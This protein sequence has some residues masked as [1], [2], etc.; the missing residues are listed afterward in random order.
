MLMDKITP[1]RR[2]WNMSRIRSEDTAPERLIRS[3][4]H[5][6]GFRFRLHAKNLPGKPDIVMPKY[7]TIIDVRGCFWHHHA[8]C[9]DGQIPKTRHEWWEAKLN[10]NST[11]DKNNVQM[12][13]SLH[14]NV[15]IIWHCFLEHAKSPEHIAEVVI[16]AIQLCSHRAD[17][18]AYE[19]TTSGELR[20]QKL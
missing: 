20:R 18:A 16:S 9:R 3:I 19:I 7:R 11:R 4:L 6:N 17:N 1:E 14:W 13:L 10:V 5:R 2:S 8:T 15:L 12:L